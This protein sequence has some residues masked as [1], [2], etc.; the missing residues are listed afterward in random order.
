V[1]ASRRAV[2]ASHRVP[3]QDVEVRQ[4]IVGGAVPADVFDDL[5][6]EQAALDGILGTLPEVAWSSPSW[7]VGWTVADVV[8]HLA[9]TEEFAAAAVHGRPPPWRRH[10]ETVDAAMDAL[11]RSESGAPPRV[12]LIR[13]RT[14][15][16][17]SLTA[18]RH[19]D[20][21]DRLL[22]VA[23]TLKPA[24]L[25]TTRL[26][27]HWAH[28]LDITEPLG[29]AYPDTARLRHIAWLAHSTLP[30][31][32]RLAD[33]RPHPVYCELTGPDGATWTFG[34][35]GA[36]SSITGPAAAFCRVAAQRLRPA[37]SGLETT[38]PDGET[39]LRVLRTYAVT[40]PDPA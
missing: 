30:Y 8:L 35:A 5:A 11:V 17:A 33:H 4:P 9:Q 19:A 24:T 12:V 6:A 36:P 31:A 15:C 21:G 28:A 40:S 1:A 37:D 20:P 29:I 16:A 39:A 13:W 7:A 3:A 25:A 27:E 32:F 26:A 22:W 10:G 2:G 23:S 18:M 14:A 34:D 38:G